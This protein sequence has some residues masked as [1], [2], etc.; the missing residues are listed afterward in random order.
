M[1]ELG[2]IDDVGAILV[3]WFAKC[4]LAMAV[5]PSR[6][7]ARLTVTTTDAGAQKVACMNP[8]WIQT[9]AGLARN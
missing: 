2:I 3:R 8:I 1:A 7:Q 9:T 6:P 4:G 5:K